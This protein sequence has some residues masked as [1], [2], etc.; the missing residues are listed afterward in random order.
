[1]FSGSIEKDESH[2][3]VYLGPCET[4]K[5]DLFVKTISDF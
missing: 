3:K 2:E 5:M 4:Y 1:M